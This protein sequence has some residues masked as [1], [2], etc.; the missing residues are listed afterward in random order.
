[1]YSIVVI[2][3]RLSCFHYLLSIINLL[4]FSLI[5]L[6]VPLPINTWSTAAYSLI[7]M[8]VLWIVAPWLAFFITKGYN[9]PAQIGPLS[10]YD[11]H[12]LLIVGLGI[13]F[14]GT[15]IGPVCNAFCTTFGGIPTLP[16]EGQPFPMMS[17]FQL[18]S[19]L[20][21]GLQLLLSLILLFQN[22]R[23][24]RLLCGKVPKRVTE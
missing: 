8:I 4:A 6:P 19:I 12:C 9:T 15:S 14:F 5:K 16:I 1:M 17:P 21:P 13:Y 10:L 22:Q 2:L 24:A 23:L 3:I 11:F 18:F 7:I 20:S